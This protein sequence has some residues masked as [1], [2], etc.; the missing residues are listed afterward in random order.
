MSAG[1][2]EYTMLRRLGAV[3][4]VDPQLCVPDEARADILRRRES[5]LE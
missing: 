5:G 3:D 1:I 2:V 4:A